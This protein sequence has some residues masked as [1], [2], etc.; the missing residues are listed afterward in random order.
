MIKAPLF[1]QQRFNTFQARCIL[2]ATYDLLLIASY[3]L[4]FSVI[5]FYPALEIS[6]CLLKRKR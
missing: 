2:G 6:L 3:M 1:S 5:I 4:S